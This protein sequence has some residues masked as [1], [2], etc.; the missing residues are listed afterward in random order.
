VMSDAQ[1]SV[2]AAVLVSGGRV[3]VVRGAEELLLAL[4]QWD[5]PRAR[6]VQT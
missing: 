1:M 6:R 4:D 2:C 3:A 5:V